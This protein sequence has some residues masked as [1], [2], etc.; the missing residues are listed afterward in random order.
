MDAGHEE[1]GS[2]VERGKEEGGADAAEEVCKEAGPDPFAEPT[3]F[4]RDL[5]ALC[6][7]ERNRKDFEEAGGAEDESDCPEE[8]AEELEVG[9]EEFQDAVAEEECGEE[10]RGGSEQ[11]V[12]DRGNDGADRADEVEGV[13]VGGADR[14]KGKPGGKI[15]G[16]VGNQGKKEQGSADE[17]GQ[18]EGFLEMGLG[19][20]GTGHVGQDS[21]RIR[22]GFNGGER[23]EPWGI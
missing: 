13:L 18:A 10:I 12:A 15:P 9:G 22:S 23:P 14:G 21:N 11:G 5:E 4:A 2:Q 19:S 16:G 17:H 1:E 7:D 20:G 6:V 8:F 3:A